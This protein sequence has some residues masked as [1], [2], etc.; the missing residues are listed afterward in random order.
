MTIPEDDL[1]ERSL[2][3]HLLHVQQGDTPPLRFG[4]GGTTVARSVAQ[5]KARRLFLHALWR[6]APHTT[7]AL[8]SGAPPTTISDFLER[9]E[10][11]D[12]EN[13]RAGFESVRLPDIMLDA[14][15][16]IEHAKGEH[17][18]RWQDRFNLP[19]A[20]IARSARLTLEAANER[21]RRGETYD[22]PLVLDSSEVDASTHSDD[23]GE[24]ILAALLADG[25]DLGSFDPRRETVNDA[26]DRLLP[27]LETRLRRVLQ[28]IADDDETLN[29][30]M[31]PV[32]LK[33][34][35]AYEWLVRYQVLGRSR[36]QIAEEDGVD[37]PNVSRAVSNTAQLIG[38]TLREQQGG[39]PP[40]P[41]A[42]TKR[43]R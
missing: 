27:E 26:T 41:R 6:V 8:L 21:Y 9:Q 39:R 31:K 28:S 10:I 34:A 17:V 36:N 11:A 29:D 1:R 13:D 33:S 12:V 24:P 32:S 38:L 4:T 7:E 18:S 2:F 22:G 20:W 43:V 16:R 3:E 37:R 40:K 35:N 14:A 30:A 25:D 23:D 5:M 19:D 42:I 15:R